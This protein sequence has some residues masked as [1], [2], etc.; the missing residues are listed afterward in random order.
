MKAASPRRSLLTGI[1][2]LG[3]AEIHLEG[4]VYLLRRPLRLPPG[5][6]NLKVPSTVEFS[7]DAIL[8]KI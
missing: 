1:A 4:G 8:P 2:D 6:G 5:I 7:M 3:G